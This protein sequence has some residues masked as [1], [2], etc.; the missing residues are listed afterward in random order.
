MKN[1]KW[2]FILVGLASIVFLSGCGTNV[3]NPAPLNRSTIWG[4]AIGF[5]SDS[6]DFFARL[7]H[8]YGVAILIVTIIVRLLTVPLMIRQL[9]YS[10]VMQQL[11]PEIAKLKEKHKGDPQKVNQETMKLFQQYG[12]NPLA[13]CLPMLIQMPILIIL[14]Q[15]IVHNPNIYNAKF[16]GI[17]PLAS[18][19]HYVLPVLTGLSTYLQQKMMMGNVQDPNQK[20]MLYLMPAM[21]FIFSFNFPAALSLYMIFSGLFTM[22]QTYFTK[23]L[24]VNAGGAERK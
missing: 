15:S 20:M 24:R 21:M 14:Y 12:A 3:T 23:P 7:V 6:I 9:R 1:R 17:L 22:A 13:G 19:E 4:A 18:H 5:V 16:L 10:K 2:I 11:Q 8:D